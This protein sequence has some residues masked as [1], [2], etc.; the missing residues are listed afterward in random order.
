MAAIY[1]KHP[2]HGAK[3]ATMELEAIY[4]EGNGW[5]RFDPSLPVAPKAVEITPPHAPEAPQGD[6]KA[7][8]V[9]YTAKFGKKPYMGWD[10]ATLRSKLEGGDL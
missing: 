4:D 3:V 1:L 6:A 9:A 5:V 10:A 7:L 8:R 2:I